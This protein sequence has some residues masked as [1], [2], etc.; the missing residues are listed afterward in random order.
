MRPHGKVTAN[1][2]ATTKTI[3]TFVKQSVRKLKVSSL[4]T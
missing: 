4:C 1:S 2:G 3:G